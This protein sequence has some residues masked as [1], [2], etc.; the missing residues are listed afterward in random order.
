MSAPSSE[1]LRTRRLLRLRALAYFYRRRLRGH[2]VQELL[3]GVGIAAA[4]ALVLAASLAQGSIVSSTQRTLRAVIGPANLQVRAR[5]PTGFS[6]SLLADVERVPGV[7]RA[8]PLLERSVR[9]IGPGGKSA[10]VYLAG[11]NVSLGVLDGLGRTLPLDALRDG[12]LGLSRTSAA[13]LGPQ[14]EG[15]AGVTLVVGGVK[16]AVRVGAVL[17]PEAIGRLSGAHVAVMEL[18]A[19]QRLLGERGRV[20]RILVQTRP[21]ART[22]VQRTLRGLVGGR[23]I[24][25][26]SEQD[27]ALLSQALGPSAQASDLFAVIGALLGLLFAFNAILLTVPERRQAIA[28]LRLA[29]T[30]RSAIVQLVGFQAICLGVAAS[31]VGVAI[32]YALSRWVFHQSTGYLAQAF[33]LSGG[34]VISANTVLLAA[35]GGVLVTCVASALPLVDVRRSA[36]RDAIYLQ[37]GLPGGALGRRGYAWCL[38]GALAMLALASVLYAVAPSSALLASIALALATVLAIPIAFAAVLALARGV[39]DRAPR[40]PTLAIALGGVRATTL[41]ALALAATGAVALFGSVALGGARANLLSGIHGFAR[42]YAADAPIWVGEAEDNQATK[43]LAGDAGAA[44]IARLDGVSSVG[45]FQGAF[46]TLGRRQVWVIARPPG[47]ARSVLANQA[48]GG[49]SAARRAEGLLARGGWIAVSRQIAAEHHVRPGGVLRL[50]TPSGSVAYRVAALTTNLAWSPGVV[51]IGS[52]DFA[53]AW[54]TNAPSAL[55]VH[56]APG[57]SVARVASEIS[58]ALGPSSGLE[59]ASAAQREQK[60]D[61]LTSEGLGQLGLVSTLLV[62]TAIVALAAA[63]ASSVNQRRGALAGLRLAG[64]P[65]ARLRRILLLEASLILGAGC[66][67]GALAGI[68]GQFVMDAYLRHVTGFPV[69]TAGGTLRAVEIL[70]LVLAAALAIVAAPGWLASRVA[71]AAALAE[72]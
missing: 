8:A 53:R 67:T 29:G 70:A 49:A 55:A 51:F 26:S 48:I 22:Q 23:L 27:I 41:R 3:A 62:L 1:P 63:L 57:A 13:S 69:T 42:S 6:E 17:G 14:K 52:A 68:Y 43:Q 33:T 21:G 11:T 65:P 40:L 5:G 4:V 56:L 54:A 50:P 30:R 10:G 46:L 34:T 15:R 2:A 39:S 16:R 7:Q 35:I 58:R 44:K 59:L 60:I 31:L 19:M 38:G 25:A 28:D 37:S 64:A 12:A 72:D 66:L 36:R 24:V 32:G 61:R 71:P 47:G 20:T 45:K 18:A 9:A